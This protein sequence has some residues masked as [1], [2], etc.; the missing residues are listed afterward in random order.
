MHRL[1]TL[2]LVLLASSFLNAKHHK[3]GELKSI[4]D[5]K[6]LNGWTQKNG[7]AT[8][9]VKDGTILGTTNEVCPN[10]FLCSKSFTKLLASVR[11]QTD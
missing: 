3:S 7:T 11:G 4:F 6:T 2:A 9:V 5:G 1:F 8:Y 10:S